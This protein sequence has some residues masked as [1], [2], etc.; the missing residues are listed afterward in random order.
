MAPGTRFRGPGR[1]L[2]RKAAQGREKGLLDAFIARHRTARGR[3]CRRC[4]RLPA[5]GPRNPTSN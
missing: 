3:A 1:L 5:N 2:N 4:N